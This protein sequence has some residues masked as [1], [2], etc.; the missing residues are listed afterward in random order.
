MG[1]N[2]DSGFRCL[3][4]S[5]SGMLLPESLVLSAIPGAALQRRVM[6]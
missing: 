1:L 3:L 2:Q 6:E 4:M 5:P